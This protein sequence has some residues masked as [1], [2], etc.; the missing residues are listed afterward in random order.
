MYIPD[1]EH[2]K[3]FAA[4]LEAL[5][6]RYGTVE[7]WNRLQKNQVETLIRLERE[8]REALVCRVRGRE[9]YVKFCR[10]ISE[11]KNNILAARPYF[12]ERQEVF[13]RQ[14]AKA[15]KLNQA[16]KLYPFAV[17]YQFVLFALRQRK[18]SKNSRVARLAEDIRRLRNE[19]VE[20]NLPLGISRARVF[21]SRTPRSHL[22]YMDE[23]QTAAEGL[24][25]GVDKYSPGRGGKVDPK[26]FRSTMIG[27]MSGNLI[28][29]YSETL[30]H[31]FPVDKRKIYRGN[32]V[33]G[34]HSSGVDHVLLASQ[35]NEGPA[36][37]PGKKKQALLGAQRTTPAEIA[38]LMAAASVVSADA[39]ITVEGG[40]E[41]EAVA[42]YAAPESS[43][44]DVLVEEGD[45]MAA[46]AAA[47]G[48]LTV[49]ERK[50][51]RLRGI[52]LGAIR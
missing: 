4:T 32:K 43:R 13:A 2:F 7:D 25:S 35:V 28:E 30:I 14:I 46:M 17:N 27:R 26:V 12:R 52:K 49:F 23:I 19:I 40:G 39:T 5:I 21:Y 24:M 34:K 18:W 41:S 50:L 3:N 22:T 37:R 10:F 38:D 20:M 44:P 36:A 33:I 1:S 29:E 8:F 16:E 48:E 9:V 11:E 31:F 51:L 6:K 42:R 45:A 47:A 15:L